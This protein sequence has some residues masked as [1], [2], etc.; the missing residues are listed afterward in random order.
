MPGE[1]SL[2]KV[3]L[4]NEVLGYVTP[5]TPALAV[6]TA[7]GVR[8]VVVDGDG[9]IPLSTQVI[10]SN[11]AAAFAVGPNGNTNPVFRVVGNISSAA[12]GISV[13]GRA[14]AAGVDITVLSSGTNEN[15]VVNAKGSGTITLN[16]TATGNV[17]IGQHLAITEAKNIVL[18][19]TTG[20][21]I[22]TSA[23]QKLGFYDATPIV[24]PTL[25]TNDAT[26]IITAL[27][28]LGLVT[29]AT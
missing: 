4:G 29:A 20:T 22:G 19:T 25:D 7:A 10:E 12:T 27:V 21:K 8:T 5:G 1:G 23:S 13:T 14:A 28:A 6:E 24:K 2:V 17:V 9:S 18:G 3:M 11:A 26:G 16:P 15:L